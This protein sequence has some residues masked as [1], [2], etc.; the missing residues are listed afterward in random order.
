MNV[1]D[2]ILKL[3]LTELFPIQRSVSQGC[4]LSMSLF[5]LFQEPFYRAV[6]ASRVIRPLTLPDSKELK[7]LGYADDSTL[8]VRN[9]ESLLEI[10]NLIC[11]FEKAMSSKLNRSKTKLYGTGNWKSRELWPIDW[12]LIEKEHLY[13]LS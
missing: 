9:D 5:I 1:Y 3:I 4:P 2:I 12:C 8:L 13:T 6:V 11:K 7:I 10:G